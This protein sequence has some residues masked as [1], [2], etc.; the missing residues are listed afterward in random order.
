MKP[1]AR[2]LPSA[3][4]IALAL[5]GCGS[6]AGTAG[7][8]DAAN[9]AAAGDVS[10]SDG[11]APLDTGAAAVDTGAAAVHFEDLIPHMVNTIRPGG[12]TICSRGGEYAYFVIPGARDKVIV[13]FEGGGACWDGPTCGFASSLFKETVDVSAHTKSLSGVAGWYDHDHPGHPLKDWTHVFVSYCTGDVHWGDNVQTYGTGPTAVTIHHKG[14]V[15]TTAV[16]NWVYREF[17]S[18]QKVFVTGC[19]AGGYG[20][21]VWAPQVQQHYAAAKVYHFSDS[22][23]GVIT[24]DFFQKSFPSW[25]V[26]PHFPSFLGKASDVGSLAVLYEAIAAHFPANVYSQYN[27][28]LDSNQTFFFQA[29]GGT[30]ANAWSMQMKASIKDIEAKAPNF[31]AF[32]ADGQQHCI[33]PQANFYDAEA[34]GTKLATWLS[35]M[36]EDK[37]IANS[38]CPSCAP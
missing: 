30:D 23:A 27:T 37:P 31:R 19:S 4:A 12:D 14:A 15:N 9:D 2:S 17:P 3:I 11:A 6:S 28:V 35:D 36:T 21:I 13:E 22:A 18:P 25:N 8:A 38:Y 5:G 34:G 32:I 1:H 29:M 20:S 10:P 26:D 16:L 7:N 33:L 24:P